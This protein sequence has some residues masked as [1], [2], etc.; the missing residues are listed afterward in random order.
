MK[1]VGR[2]SEPSLLMPSGKRSTKSG[3]RGHQR[4]FLS[5]SVRGQAR[6]LEM[7]RPLR[8][9][10]RE[11][12]KHL[13]RMRKRRRRKRR[14]KK[15]SKH[16]SQKTSD[17]STNCA[18]LSI[19]SKPHEICSTFLTELKLPTHCCDKTDFWYRSNDM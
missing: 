5:G 1:V 18:S 12:R 4:S 7:L 19:C 15:K 17:L 10:K 11:V 9:R 2:L 13:Q 16:Y 6:K 3:P 14:R 8:V